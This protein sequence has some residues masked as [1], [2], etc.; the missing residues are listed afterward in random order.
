MLPVP[1]HRQKR[2]TSCFPASIRMVLNYFGDDIDELWLWKRGR[3]KGYLGTWDTKMAPYIIKKGYHV[4]SYWQGSMDDSGLPSKV[5]REYTKSLKIA[6]KAGWRYRAKANSALIKKF[7]LKGIP[8][9]AE[10]EAS[11]LYNKRKYKFTHIITLIG[12]TK[13]G[14]LYWDSWRS[15][16]KPKSITFKDFAKCW[17]LKTSY[18]KSI[19][20]IYPK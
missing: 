15:S 5:K 6:K 18:H 13:T 16:K 1:Y 10:V 2:E 8:V 11:I 7:L 14:F 17:Q 12:L 3:I 9:L 4:D 20:V 19:T